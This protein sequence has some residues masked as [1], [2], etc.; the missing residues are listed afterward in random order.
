MKGVA[1]KGCHLSFGDYGNQS[2]ECGWLTSKQIEASRIV[3]T[4]HM[5]RVG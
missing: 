5:M 4:R 2:H 3:I 1:S